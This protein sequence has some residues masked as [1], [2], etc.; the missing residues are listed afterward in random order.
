VATQSQ[1]EL[2]S[3][4][5][6]RVVDPTQH[7][8]ELAYGYLNQRDRTIIEVRR[9]LDGKDLDP[10]AVDEA[11]ATLIEQG[12]LDDVRFARLFAQD[13]RELEQWGADRIRRNLLARG[14][15]RELVEAT[16][17]EHASDDEL[18]QA[19]SL[20]RRRFTAAPTDRRERDRALGML[21]RKGYDPELAL[22]AIRAYGWDVADR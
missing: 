18:D 2:A 5:H 21:L 15:D 16:L 13:K 4:A 22:D 14:L 11:V 17:A 9:H 7:A 3:G 8:L 6:E 12:Y 10:G 20:L 1:G 19:V